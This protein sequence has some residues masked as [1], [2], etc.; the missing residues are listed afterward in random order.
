MQKLVTIAATLA[1]LVAL[2]GTVW[3]VRELGKKEAQEAAL[4][5]TVTPGAVGEDGEVD[6][7]KAGYDFYY[8][9]KLV[10]AAAEYHLAAEAGDPV[11]QRNLGFLYQRGHGVDPDP[12]IA[13]LWYRKAADQG[14]RAAYNNI[15]FLYVAGLGVKQDFVQAHYWYTK[16][17]VAGSKEGKRLRE[18]ILKKMTKEQVDAAIKLARDNGVEEESLLDF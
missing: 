4:A 7:L 1:V 15:G 11:A 10:E 16:A 2:L 5:E 9:G 6:H 14:H 3:V 13:M 12:K 8:G 18:V 17:V